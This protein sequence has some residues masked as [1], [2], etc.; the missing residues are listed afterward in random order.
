MSLE[1]PLAEHRAVSLWPQIA[2]PA[3]A[4]HTTDVS[5]YNQKLYVRLDSAALKPELILRRTGL[6]EALNKAAGTQVITDICLR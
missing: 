4:R 6:I 3:L 5:I 1:T 2:P